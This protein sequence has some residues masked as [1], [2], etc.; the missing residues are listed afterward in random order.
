MRTRPYSAAAGGR[1]GYQRSTE[2]RR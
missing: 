1:D 2:P